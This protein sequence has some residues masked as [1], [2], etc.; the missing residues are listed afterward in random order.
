MLAEERSV[1][2]WWGSMCVSVIAGILLATFLTLI[3]VPVMYSILDDVSDW[4]RR[5]YIGEAGYAASDT[6]RGS[7]QHHE[8]GGHFS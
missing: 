2:A 5:A 4:F 1:G 6:G 3:L 8:A 7:A